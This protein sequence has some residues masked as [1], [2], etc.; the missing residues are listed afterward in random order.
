MATFILIR[1]AEMSHF[2]A[3]LA[4]MKFIRR[5]GLMRNTRTENIQEHSLQVSM[6]AH[7]LPVI[8]NE[9]FGGQLDPARVALLGVYHDAEE[10][11]T[12]DLPTPIKYFNPQIKEAF[13]NLKLVAKQRLL[14]MLPADME[15]SYRTLFFEDPAEADAHQLVR[16]ADRICAYLKCIEEAK[17]GNLEFARAEQQ[18]W[19][20]LFQ[21]NV[22]EVAVFM[23][24]F[25]PSFR[26]TIDELN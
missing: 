22:P 3:Y 26:L 7:A 11:I 24:E 15:P 17:A 8:R 23:E 20:S 25:I 1:C 21:L 13:D 19:R 16:A 14:D 5:W 12:S 4:R 9:R 2:F 18:V 10:V 6:V